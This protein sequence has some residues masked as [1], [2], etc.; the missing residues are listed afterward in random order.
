[1][2]SNENNMFCLHKQIEEAEKE[3]EAESE[4]WLS[5]RAQTRELTFKKHIKHFGF[6]LNF[7]KQTRRWNQYCRSR[8]N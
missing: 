8:K 4:V 7:S 5:G 6:F 3:E 1:M 2:K